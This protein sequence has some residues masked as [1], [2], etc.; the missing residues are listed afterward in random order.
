[1]IVDSSAI[2]A[3]VMQEPDWQQTFELIATRPGSGIAAPTLLETGMVLTARLNRNMLPQLA[4]LLQE[5]VLEVTPLGDR[6]WQT[7]LNAYN[8][9]GKGRHT[10]ALNFGDC[11]AYATAKLADEPLLF[12]GNDFTATDLKSALPR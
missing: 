6:H 12:F 11:I 8:Q 4:R 9:Y 7:A 10:A 2:V 3:V 1:M 5:F